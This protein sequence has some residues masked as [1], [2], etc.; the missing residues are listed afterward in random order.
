[1]ADKRKLKVTACNEITSGTSGKGVAWTLYGIDALDENDAQVDAAV[2]LRSWQRLEIGKL[3]EY[4]VEK[5]V[6][7]QYGEQFFLSLPRSRGANLGPKVDKI[8]DDVEEL[9]GQVAD[10]AS[11]VAAVESNGVA[12]QKSPDAKRQSPAAS[13]EHR[14]DDDIPF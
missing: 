11:R 4:D 12:Q 8:R 9:K 14:S 2:E 7:P 10:L 1:M 6:D 13:T 3:V 5:K